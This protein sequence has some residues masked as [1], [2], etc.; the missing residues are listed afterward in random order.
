[1]TATGKHCLLEENFKL[2]FKFATFVVL[3]IPGAL[4]MGFIFQLIVSYNRNID[5]LC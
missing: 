1:M 5:T 2:I 4:G 3:L